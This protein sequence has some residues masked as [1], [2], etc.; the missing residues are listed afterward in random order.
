MKKFRVSLQWK[1]FLCIVL[2]ILPTP[3][4]L[5]TWAGIQNKNQSDE[6]VVNQARIL[7]RQIVLNRQTNRTDLKGRQ[8]IYVHS[9]EE[10][11]LYKKTI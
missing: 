1:F 7:S 10:W 3:G 2:I 8:L 11:I 9:K 5:F 4:I 6:Q